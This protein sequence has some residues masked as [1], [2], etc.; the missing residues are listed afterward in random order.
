MSLEPDA[1]GTG[2]HPS[3]QQRTLL[4]SLCSSALG[5]GAVVLIALG[6]ISIVGPTL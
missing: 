1:P 5:S 2:G 3:F 6:L 4:P